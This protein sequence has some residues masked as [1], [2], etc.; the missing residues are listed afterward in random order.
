MSLCNL[1]SIPRSMKPPT[2]SCFHCK[3]KPYLFFNI[4]SIRSLKYFMD[5]SIC[6][7]C[8]SHDCVYFILIS[9]VYLHYD[10]WAGRFLFLIRNWGEIAKTIDIGTTLFPHMVSI[11]AFTAVLPKSNSGSSSCSSLISQCT[12]QR[13]TLNFSKVLSDL[14]ARTAKCLYYIPVTFGIFFHLSNYQMKRRILVS[15]SDG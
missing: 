8:F 5:Q 14:W 2:L 15:I 1:P 13:E 12:P 6:I 9:F 11:V 3:P 7:T 4:Y 10:F